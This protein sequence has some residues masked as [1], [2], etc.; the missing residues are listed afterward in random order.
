MFLKFFDELSSYQD[1]EFDLRRQYI[2][3]VPYLRKVSERTISRVLFGMT[4]KHF[5]HGQNILS[6]G[7]I[8][9]D[10]FILWKGEIDVLVTDSDG[11]N[12]FFDKLNEGSCF[13]VY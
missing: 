8:Q 2:R 1:F 12:H 4:E 11:R 6:K 10:I 7:E 13:S 5:E 3:N 9:K